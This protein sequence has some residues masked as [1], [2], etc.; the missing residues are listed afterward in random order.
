MQDIINRKRIGETWTRI[1]MQYKSTSKTSRE[2][3]RL[4]RPVL[5][6]YKC[7]ST[8]HLAKICTKK[9]KINEVQVIEVVQC[10]EEKEESDLNSAVYEDTPVK[11]YPIENITAF[12]EVAE[13][14]IHLP[15]YSEDCHNLIK[16]RDS[17]M[18]KAK[19]ARGK[20]Y[21]SG[22]SCIKSVLINDIEARVSLDTGAFCI[23]VGKDYYQSILPG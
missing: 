5:K 2:D 22:E 19:P 11:E 10:T 17:I 23:C 4:E 16:G 15:E 21:T 7:E 14:H 20:G 13:V 8:S 1:L 9:T 18:C 6:C 3:K 12:F